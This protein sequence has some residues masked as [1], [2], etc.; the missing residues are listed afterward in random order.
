MAAPVSRETTLM[1]SAGSLKRFQVKP[2]FPMQNSREEP[3]QHVLDIDSAGQPANSL[4]CDA[5]A[6]PPPPRPER[7]RG[8]SSAAA[9]SAIAIRCL[10]RVTSAFPPPSDSAAASPT[11]SINAGS[12]SPVTD[13]DREFRPAP[14]RAARSTLVSDAPDRSPRRIPAAAA[15]EAVQS[16]SHSTRSARSRRPLAPAARLRAR[17]ANP[18]PAGRPCRR[19]A[20]GIRRDRAALPARLASCPPPRSRSPHPAARSR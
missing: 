4:A 9:A 15:S 6:S 19:A 2:H 14:A 12:P 18:P 7:P 10:C 11:R 1:H 5:A 8:A 3:V 17:P 13:G 16:C 20:P